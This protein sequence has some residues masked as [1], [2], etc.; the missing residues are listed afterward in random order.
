MTTTIVKTTKMWDIMLH[1]SGKSIN[2]ASNKELDNYGINK[3]TKN[4]APHS[5]RFE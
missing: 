2:F 1:N 3:N 5:K 4:T